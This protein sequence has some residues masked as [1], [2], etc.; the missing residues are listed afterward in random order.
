MRIAFLVVSFL[1]SFIS[2]SA[3]TSQYKRYW[4]QFTDKNNNPFSLSRP[5]E[6]LSPRALD[7]RER[8]NIPLDEKDLPVTPAYIDSIASTGVKILT[9]SRWLNSVTIYTGDSLA[10][11]RINSF[12]FVKSY[13]PSGSMIAP[14]EKIKSE[15]VF[16]NERNESTGT[17][18]GLAANQIDMLHGSVLHQKG[19]RGNGIVIAMLD[20]G[21]LNVPVLSVFDSL[22]SE[23]RILYTYDFVSGNTSV[24]EDDSH[25]SAC[26]SAIAANSPGLMVGTAPKASFLLLRTEDA[27]SEYPV[28][29]L[30]WAAAAEF[31]DSAGAD[32]ISSSLG[33]TIF[34]DSVFN[35]KYQ[36]MNGLTAPSSIAA[37]VAASRGMIVCVSAGNSAN[38][39]PGKSWYYISAP[40]DADGIL[41]VGAVDANGYIASFSSRGP[42]ADGRI[43]PDV[44][45]QGANTI[46]S[47]PW[48]NI[49][50]AN[51]GT[52][53]SCPLIAGMTACLW[54]AHPEKTS[55]E[56]ISAVKQSSSF[57]LSPDNDY[58]YGIPNYA[59][60]DLILT[61]VPSESISLTNEPFIF[62]NPFSDN[63][64]IIYFSDEKNSTVTLDYYD[65]Q[66]RLMK[67]EQQSCSDGVNQLLP[68][69]SSFAAGSYF[70]RIHT[71]KN[72]SLVRAVKLNRH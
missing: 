22:V 69:L 36:D 17:N 51:S 23:N 31:A 43:K 38:G 37:S 67:T 30:N 72:S 28:E 32:M 68:D 11:L 16:I 41:T 59:L 44:V 12:P 29:E 20:A 27:G 18:Y 7:R 2:A 61:G 55:K 47:Y 39:S 25:G 26:L 4:I 48:A 54:Q 14:V 50:G 24:F 42:T 15:P 13:N 1:L 6:F 64:V 62:P 21:F 53:L 65:M 34:S 66:G 56:I 33:Y 40:A 46:V 70:I 10:L 52:S 49:V 5:S 63:P 9:R 3:Q 19:F 35:Y 58:G 8:Q 45:A 57:Y 60:A 71:T